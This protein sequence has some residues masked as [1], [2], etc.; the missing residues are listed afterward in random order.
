MS[1]QDDSSDFRELEQL[2]QNEPDAYRSQV[3]RLLALGYAYIGLGSLILV[4]VTL[5]G[6]ALFLSGLLSIVWLNDFLKIGVPALLLAGAMLRS[7]FVS[8]PAP[9]GHYLEGQTKTKLLDAIEDIRLATNGPKLDE[10]LM[11]HELNA[12]VVQRPRFG[13]FGGN[14]N[15]LILGTTLLQ[16]LSLEEFRA[17]VAHEFGHL[18]EQHGVMGAQ[19]YRLNHTLAHAASE[20]QQKTQARSNGWQFA[21][22][23]WFYPKFDRLTFAMRR[24]QEYE[25]DCQAAQATSAPA[26]ASAL[27]KL[28]T[29]DEPLRAFWATQ[30]KYA[31]TEKNITNIF[32]NRDLVAAIRGYEQQP[33]LSELLQQAMDVETEFEDSHPA[34][35]DRLSALKEPPQITPTSEPTAAESLFQEQDQTEFVTLADGLWQRENSDNWSE[36]HTQFCEAQ[37][38]VTDLQ[39]RHNTLNENELLA[40]LDLEDRYSDL[41]DQQRTIGALVKRFPNNPHGNYRFGLIHV[42]SDFDRAETHL[43]RSMVADSGYT[44][45]VTDLLGP[46]YEAKDRDKDVAR[47]QE[48]RDK[49]EASVDAANKERDSLSLG[50][51]LLPPGLADTDR[52]L[53]SSLLEQYIEIRAVY[54]ARKKLEHFTEHDKY[55]ILIDVNTNDDEVD[56]DESIWLDRVTDNIIDALPLLGHPFRGFYE[57]DTDFG[58][59]IAE[60]AEREPSVQVYLRTKTMLQIATERA[61]RQADSQPVFAHISAWITIASCVSIVGWFA[62]W[63]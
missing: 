63:W 37:A 11:T 33:E 42:E 31:E 30:W 35:V 5:G 39:A 49:Y 46:A 12:A 27:C 13:L 50:D 16:T 54:L 19:V 28:N 40:L 47:N 18:T 48:W 51:E 20:I 29:L 36:L 62:D 7:V 1:S 57:K 32:P 25:A 41:E 56:F 58:Q 24:G 61:K 53:L 45:A 60:F 38:E 10:V 8:I 34:L 44:R 52:E 9:A 6:A 21:F 4:G 23:N 22:F 3:R 17:V 43:L 59:H 55:L 15:Y 26:I 2:Y 14:R